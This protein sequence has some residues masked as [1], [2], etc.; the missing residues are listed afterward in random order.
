MKITVEI[1]TC[2]NCRHMDHSGA[3]TVRGARLICS[4]SDACSKRVTIEEFLAE[5]PEY[6]DRDLTHFKY[7]WIH[8]VLSRSSKEEP[9]R[10]PIWCPL[11]R[12]AKY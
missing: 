12:G 6:K 9:T 10:I 11:K 3:F 8:R 1:N 7:H 2:H 5:Y 4:H